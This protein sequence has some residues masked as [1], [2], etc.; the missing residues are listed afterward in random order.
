M[1]QPLVIEVVLNDILKKM[2]FSECTIE[3]QEHHGRLVWNIVLPGEDKAFSTQDEMRS[4]V[5]IVHRILEKQG[6]DEKY[7]IDVNGRQEMYVKEIEA[8]AQMLAER[9][10]SFHSRAEMVPMNSYERMVVHALFSDDPEITTIS[11]GEGA[12]RHVVLQYAGSE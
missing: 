3:K 2:G 7:T 5:Y 9:V 8:K 6:S 10:R 12:S 4:L 1:T 11:E